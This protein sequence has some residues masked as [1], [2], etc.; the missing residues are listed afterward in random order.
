MTSLQT[1]LPASLVRPES[2]V[3]VKNRE[4]S[5]HQPAGVVRPTTLEDV[6]QLVRWAISRNVGLTVIGGR[7][8]GHCRQPG[9]L[10]L[11]TRSFMEVEI[12]RD[13]EMG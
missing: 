9:I 12:I 8:S 10:A 7:H 11:D 2:E 13:R 1:G 4:A 6:R 5:L 3:R